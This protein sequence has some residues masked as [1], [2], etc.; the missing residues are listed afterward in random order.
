M[1]RRFFLPVLAATAL[2]GCPQSPTQSLSGPYAQTA[3]AG[4]LGGL[5]GDSATPEDAAVRDTL[6]KPTKVL[7]P[8][9]V[10][11]LFYGYTTALKAEDQ[12]ALIGTV[13][14]ELVD[15]GLVK[16]ALQVPQA[17]VGG[18]PNLS[19]LRKLAARFQVDVLLLLSGQAGVQYADAQ[20]T[21]FFDSFGS[22]AWFEARASVDGLAVD[23]ASGLFFT[24]F[25]AAGSAGPVQTDRSAGFDAATYPLAKQ[26]ETKALEG[27]KD[28]LVEALK[29]VK[30][31][32]GNN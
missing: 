14:Q 12:A 9:R 8:A 23:V 26:A 29:A 28:R 10:G 18:S 24:S 19:A 4:A 3:P 1:I 16:S 21:S 31:S 13:R 11:L 30:A 25:K 22:K 17:L 32:E 7:F 5:I 2:A 27:A 6:L 15:T 20:P